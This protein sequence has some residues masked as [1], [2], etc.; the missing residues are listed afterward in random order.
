MS[1]KMSPVFTMFLLLVTVMRLL[2]NP[3]SASSSQTLHILNIK[4][5]KRL[6]K[7]YNIILKF[8]NKNSS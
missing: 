5:K 4:F 1:K 6:S 8:K 2:N 3:N 7:F